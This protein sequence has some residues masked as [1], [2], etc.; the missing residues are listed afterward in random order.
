MH[1][2]S[3]LILTLGLAHADQ[4]M[5]DRLRTAHFP[6]DRNLVGAHVTLFHHLPAEDEPGIRAVLEALGPV[7]APFA[8]VAAGLRSLGRGTAFVL[9]SPELLRLRGILARSW[10]DALSPQDRQGFRPHVTIQNKV[11]PT[12][13]RALLAELST[14]FA[15]FTVTAT[16]LLLWRYRGG[17]WDAAGGFAF[18]G[19]PAG[20]PARPHR[21]PSF[22]RS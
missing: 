5:F 7:T 22:D 12:D 20:P 11:A 14:G 9:Q 15:P 8:V 10:A 4:A 21:S 3:P 19:L 2:D 16:G 17:P 18:T 6:P 13:A 1:D